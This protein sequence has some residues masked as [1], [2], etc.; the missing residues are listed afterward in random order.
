M[1]GGWIVQAKYRSVVVGPDE[2]RGHREERED[3]EHHQQARTGRSTGT[4]VAVV[5]TII[6]LTTSTLRRLTSIS[7]RSRQSPTAT[8]RPMNGDSPRRLCRRQLGHSPAG[9]ALIAPHDRRVRVFVS[10]TLVELAAEREAARE[11]ITRCGSRR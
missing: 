2:E 1:S 8:G 5:S 3:A 6:S 9:E 11:A 10:S 7:W 4:C